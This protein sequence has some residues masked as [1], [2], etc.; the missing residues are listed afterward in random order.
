M[1]S[2]SHFEPVVDE[3]EMALLDR[4]APSSE[5]PG[6]PERD[7]KSSSF[8][9]LKKGVTK[10]PSPDRKTKPSVDKGK[11]S[12]SRSPNRKSKAATSSESDEDDPVMAAFRSRT[13]QRVRFSL[14]ET[15]PQQQDEMDKNGNGIKKFMTGALFGPKSD[16][17]RATQRLN[18]EFEAEVMKELETVKQDPEMVWESSE[19][20]RDFEPAVVKSRAAVF[21]SPSMRT[22][23]TKRRSQNC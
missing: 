16:S 3:P 12:P 1:P 8:S 7:K 15:P 9:F 17:P 18:D 23:K 22:R 4:K 13:K 21:N 14:E 6:S 11:K 2:R 5:S 19:S 10:S 20:G